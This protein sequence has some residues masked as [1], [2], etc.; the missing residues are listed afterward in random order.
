MKKC[1][2]CAEEIQDEAIKCRYCN[3]FLTEAPRP[4][5]DRV[6][7][8]C[9]PM[10]LVIGFV[11]F[12]PF[13]LPLVWLHPKWTAAKK[14]VITIIILVISFMLYKVTVISLRSIGDYYKL[15]PGHF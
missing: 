8:Y 15:M 3:E 1:P 11:C 6:G 13:I 14:G 10:T 7:W 12:G 9:K 5:T 2:F 4:G